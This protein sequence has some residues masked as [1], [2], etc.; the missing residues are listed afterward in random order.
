LGK[1]IVV[2]SGKGGVGKTTI[3]GNIGTGLALKGKRVVLIDVDIGLRNLDLVLGLENRIVYTIMDVLDGSCKLSQALVK[4]KRFKNRL[5]L[6]P[7]AQTRMKEEIK[8][9]DLRD[10][11]LKLKKEFDFVILDSPAGIEHGFRLSTLS[12]DE[13]IVVTT[14]EITAI[15]DADRV[16]GLLESMEIFDPKLIINRVKFDMVKKG[17]MLDWKDISDI[18]SVEVIGLVPEDEYVTI[19]TNMGEPAILNQKSPGGREMMNIVRR[20]LGEDVPIVEE[21]PKISVVFTILLLMFNLILFKRTFAQTDLDLFVKDVRISKTIIFEGDSF[22]VLVN[23]GVQGEW[24]EVKENHEVVV[25]LFWDVPS[26]FTLIDSKIITVDQKSVLVNFN[27]S[28]EEKD[29]ISESMNLIG[30]RYLVVEVDSG[31]DLPELNEKNN[32][33]KEKIH[34]FSK[35]ST[36]IDLWIGKKTA[37]INSEEY[38]LD[39]PPVIKDGRTLVPI[40]FIAEGFGSYVFWF[41][42]DKKVTIIYE[43]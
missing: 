19:S 29:F 32:V 42:K 14:P 12:S 25:S 5:Y 34:I 35:K 15:R 39:V 27:V 21:K 2:T 20:M 33:F 24:E 37:F 13:A 18:L 36:I 4:D 7:A 26:R 40:R 28:L 16:I 11:V 22:D 17:E 10:I 23:L 30:D 31:H 1:S 3:V 41:N 6:L 9:E 43:G 8:I 38:E